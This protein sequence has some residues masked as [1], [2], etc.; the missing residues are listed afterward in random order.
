MS[1]IH[2]CM[3]MKNVRR[4]GVER[5]TIPKTDRTHLGGGGLFSGQQA[6]ARSPL[7]DVDDITELPKHRVPSKKRVVPWEEDG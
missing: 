6:N 1:A 4:D 5:V 7:T 2:L 3:K